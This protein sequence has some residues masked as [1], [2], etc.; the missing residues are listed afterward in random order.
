LGEEVLEEP[1]LIDQ[2]FEEHSLEGQALEDRVSWNQALSD[3]VLDEHPYPVH[4]HERPARNIRLQVA[5]II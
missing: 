5:I 1:V 2:A 3:L 4:L